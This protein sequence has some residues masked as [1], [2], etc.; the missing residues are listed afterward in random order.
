MSY[1]TITELKLVIPQ[2]DL[3]LLTDFDGQATEVDDSSLQA[4]LDDATAE[5]NGYISKSVDLP[6]E[7]PPSMLRVV[8]RDLAVH[9]LY[10]N[11]SRVTE[12]Q[13]NLREAGISYL[14]MAR[15]GNVS[16]GATTGG[17]EEETSPG[18]V[19]SE[20]PDRVMTRDSLRRY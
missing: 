7:S 3:I 12:E 20:G 11:I 1:A 9:R 17:D 8:C 15:D 19:I 6:L 2:G 16:R 13:K 5:I 14:E 4:A 10:A 18:P